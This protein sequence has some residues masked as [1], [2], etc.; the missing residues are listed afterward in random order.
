MRGKQVSAPYEL[1][2]KHLAHYLLRDSCLFRTIV[3]R[4]KLT[5]DGKKSEENRRETEGENKNHP[6]MGEGKR[7]E[8]T[9]LIM[10]IKT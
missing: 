10:G 7:L 6:G 1:T 8:E 2:K 5:S 3:Q 9:K 4:A